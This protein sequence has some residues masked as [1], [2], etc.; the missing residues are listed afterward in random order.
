M[1]LNEYPDKL[2]IEEQKVHAELIDR[3]NKKIDMLAK[4]LDTE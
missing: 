2:I 3:M 1:N 4:D